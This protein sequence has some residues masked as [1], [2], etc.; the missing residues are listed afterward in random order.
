MFGVSPCFSV[1]RGTLRL[2]SCTPQERRARRALWPRMKALRLPQGLGNAAQETKK[3]RRRL[4]TGR[5]KTVKASLCA[6][7]AR[8]P[9]REF[10]PIQRVWPAPG[11][12]RPVELI[13]RP[14]EVIGR[15]NIV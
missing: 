3:A 1:H 12:S 11:Q 8:L 7:L 2:I 4:A 10:A 9:P 13:A 6:Q 15:D 14:D 5:K